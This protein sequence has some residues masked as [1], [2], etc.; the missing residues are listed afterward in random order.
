MK[1]QEKDDNGKNRGGLTK[2]SFI[3][4]QIRIYYKNRNYGK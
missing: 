2:T 4:K 1:N 3:P